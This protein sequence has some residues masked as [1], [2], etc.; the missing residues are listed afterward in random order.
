MIFGQGSEAYYS[1]LMCE[2]L[3]A[4]ELTTLVTIRF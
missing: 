3:D 2:A 1:L 4:G